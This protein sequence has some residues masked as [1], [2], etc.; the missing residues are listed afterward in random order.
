M[1]FIDIKYQKHD[2]NARITACQLTIFETENSSRQHIKGCCWTSVKIRG[3]VRMGTCEHVEHSEC[4]C[5][6]VFS[7]CELVNVKL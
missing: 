6:L 7:V 3:N 4:V 1:R 2:S 5:V